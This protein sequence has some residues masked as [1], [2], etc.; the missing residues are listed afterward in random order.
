MCDELVQWLLSI[1]HKRAVA[2]LQ[3]QINRAEGLGNTG[4]LMDLIRQKQEIEQKRRGF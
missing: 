3:E 1:E 4:L 2:D